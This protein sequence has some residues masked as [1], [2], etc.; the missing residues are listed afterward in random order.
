MY[1]PQPGHGYEARENYFRLAH[2]CWE[3]LVRS[4]H[5][6][7]PILVGDMNLPTFLLSDSAASV[8]ASGDDRL[9]LLFSQHFASDGCL[10]NARPPHLATHI[11]GNILDL[12]IAYTSSSQDWSFRVIHELRVAGSDHFPLVV[13]IPGLAI[14]GAGCTRDPKWCS[15]KDFPIQ[16]F[17]D[18][19]TPLL[20]SLH[21]WLSTHLWPPPSDPAELRD[22]LL[23][24]AAVLSALLLGVLFQSNSPYGRFSMKPDGGKKRR[25]KLS[26][27]LRLAIQRMRESRGTASYGP[28][29]RTVNR[30][31]KAHRLKRYT[32]LTGQPHDC[33]RF[34]PNKKTFDW[35]R[36]EINP[37]A[38]ASH[39]I[40]VDNEL[41]GDQVAADIWV[42]FL[43]SQ[44]SWDGQLSP[45]V[46][47]Q[48]YQGHLEERP[49]EDP[50]R[51]TARS[52]YRD[53]RQ[54]LRELPVEDRAES[55]IQWTE[56]CDSL[57]G[58]NASAAPPPTEAVPVSILKPPCEPLRACL[59]GLLNLAI[60]CD[61]LPPAWCVVVI[62]P[63]LKPG[64]PKNRI[65]SHRPISLMPLAL[66]LLDRIMFHRV[67]PAIRSQALPW[68]LGGSKGPDLAIAYMGDMLRLRAKRLIDCVVVLLDGQSA[69][70]RPPPLAMVSCLR[71]LKQLRSDDIRIIHLVLGSICSKPVVLGRVR[72]AHKHDV[73]LPQGGALSTALFVALTLLLYDGLCDAD[74]ACHVKVDDIIVP[75][76][77][78]GFVDDMAIFTGDL[79][80]AQR[81]LDTAC[82]WANHIRMIFNLG[83]DKSAQ[84]DL[85]PSANHLSSDLFLYGKPLPRTS[86]YRYL[87]ALFTAT[88]SVAAALKDMGEKIL[89]KTGILVGWGRVNQVPLAHLVRLW[90]L[91]VEPIV[92]WLVAA[93]PL[94]AT[95]AS[96]LDLLQRKAGRLLLGHHKR[97]PRL[98]SLACLGWVPWSCLLGANRLGLWGRMMYDDG[99]LMQQIFALARTVEGTWAHQVSVDIQNVF[100][101]NQPSDPTTFWGDL[102]RYRQTCMELGWRE[103]VD[104][105]TGH[106]RLTHFPVQLAERS[107]SKTGISD[108]FTCIGL[109]LD[110]SI[111]VLRLF[112]GG[113]GLRAGDTCD[114]SPTSRGNCCLFCLK[115]GSLAS[116]T[117]RHFLCD[118]P[119][120]TVT[121][122]ESTDDLTDL[123][124]HPDAWLTATAS[125]KR[126]EAAAEK[127]TELTKAEWRYNWQLRMLFTAK[128]ALAIQSEILAAYQEPSFQVACE[129]VNASWESRDSKMPLEQK[130]Q[131]IEALCQERALNRILPKYGFRADAS[132][133]AQMKEAVGRF[134]KEDPEVRRKQMEI[135]SAVMKKFK[136]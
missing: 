35:I 9:N 67:W 81:A 113:Q 12:A 38:T 120:S 42:E 91:Y 41:L 115:H 124:L 62:V 13:G 3:R 5:T 32:S 93:V 127:K 99:N 10:L 75:M 58:L 135:T 70:C 16:Q 46:L 118:C 103:V 90:L 65:E 49:C 116:D 119:L 29:Q 8:H 15:F 18:E 80:A 69:Y 108:L 130:M 43:R 114:D 63:L 74:C 89:R 134:T 131:S 133:I 6:A 76:V 86:S 33:F 111:V 112:C 45:E 96:W 40:T 39:M 97:S 59:I 123:L 64:K 126:A 129:E 87:G 24:G 92:W 7:L 50:P 54:W 31:L 14:R 23:Q 107:D 104:G 73:G 21:S 60:L 98:S 53:A 110:C 17:I 101:L 109:S 34:A 132:G 72:A 79:P 56:F 37:D 102:K 128:T 1:A 95:Q 105:C 71:R 61:F 55:L 84:L 48:L 47:L 68:Q 20:Q 30:A 78:S 100:A 36:D 57:V 44:T 25:L 52:R 122:S 125:R 94:T 22:V 2:A 19:V 11:K 136:L 51:E 4:Y 88:G 82:D 117:L 77:A 28:L 83:P 121:D 66:K 106:S 27:K 26:A 85:P